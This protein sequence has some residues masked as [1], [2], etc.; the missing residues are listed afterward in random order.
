[1]FSKILVPLNGTPESNIALPLARTIA[2][3]TGASITLLRVVPPPALPEHH[4]AMSAAGE[5]LER[6]AAELASGGFEVNPVIRQG[7]PTE[8]ILHLA[9]DI[10]A[11]LLVMRTR[12]RGGFERAVLGSVTEQ[13]LSRSRVPLLLLRPGGHRVTHVGKLLVPVDGSPGG[14]IAVNIAMDLARMTGASMHILE[15]VV[16][17][18]AQLFAAYDASILSA[19]DS[20]WDDEALVSARVYIH[21]VAARLRQLGLSVD[22]EARMA[23]SVADAIVM[24]AEDAR[25][26]VIVMSTQALTGP[27]RALL[28]SVTDAVV[29][30]SRCPVLVIH[31]PNA[32]EHRARVRNPDPAMLTI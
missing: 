29:R 26:D 10:G 14:A 11:D 21:A 25:A 8:E 6:V 1:M 24:A 32:R 23:A 20:A 18:S 4:E 13:V 3:A 28:G 15:V 12:R 22:A 19:Y 16:P 5:R 27:A 17:I 2:T 30:T 7:D 31:R 9:R